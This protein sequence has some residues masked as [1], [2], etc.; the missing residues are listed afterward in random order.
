MAAPT[1]RTATLICTEALKQAGKKNPIASQITRAEDEWLRAFLRSLVTYRFWKPLE[2]KVSGIVTAFNNEIALPSDFQ[3]IRKVKLFYG[4]H[5]G[6]CTA[7][8]A[9]TIT[10]AADEDVTE[11]GA[12]FPIFIT[13]GTYI[14]AKR[15]IVG[16]NTT[17]KVATINSNWDNNPAPADGYLIADY[18][19]NLTTPPVTKDLDTVPIRLPREFDIYGEPPVIRM[20]SVVDNDRSYAYELEYYLDIN[21]VDLAH[22]RLTAV[23]NK[24]EDLLIQ[25][26]KIYALKDI[27]DTKR[28]LLETTTLNAMLKNHIA[29][30]IKQNKQEAVAAFQYRG[31]MPIGR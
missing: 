21:K 13:S 8:A 31:G 28:A 16:Y 6:A 20:D 14:G 9:G 18:K 5:E 1:N 30:D 19:V 10:L 3:A 27:P 17:T 2:T 7:V 22:A 24:F 29:T 11:D 4:T 26:V 15:R 23:Y 12:K 25:G